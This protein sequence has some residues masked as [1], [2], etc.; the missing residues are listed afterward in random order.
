MAETAG[1]LNV[2]ITGRADALDRTLRT[3]ERRAVDSGSRMEK[4]LTQALSFGKLV[5]GVKAFASATEIAFSGFEYVTARIEGNLGKAY[6]AA[7]KFASRM[8][9]IPLVG[10][11]FRLG[12]FIGS[13]G[14]DDGAEAAKIDRE[15]TDSERRRQQMMKAAEESQKRIRDLTRETALLGASDEEARKR[16][17]AGFNRDDATAGLASLPP[18]AQAEIR[19]L[20]ETRFKLETQARDAGIGTGSQISAR[21]ALSVASPEK[22]GPNK[23]Q[24]DL[25]NQILQNIVRVIAAQ[26][27]KPRAQ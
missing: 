25:T 16:L 27:N 24:V 18:A 26:D 5:A 19:R 15:T 10:D 14:V 6:E 22:Q 17:R 13:G 1:T 9:E 7:N 12:Q 4:S 2:E 11:A 8:K 3:A 21:T 23:K 20:A